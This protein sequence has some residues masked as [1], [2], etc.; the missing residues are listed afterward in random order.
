MRCDALE[1]A[2]VRKIVEELDDT[3]FIVV[4]S[5]S[6]AGGGLVKRRVVH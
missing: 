2:K 3:A 6:D 1:I 4:Q 5:I